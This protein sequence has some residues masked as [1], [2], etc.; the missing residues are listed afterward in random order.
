[1]Q[2]LTALLLAALLVPEPVPT[3]GPLELGEKLLSQKQYARAEAELQRAVAADPTSARAHGNLALAFLP[4]RKVR[5]ALAEARLAAAFGPASPEAHYIY[6][7]ALS[8]DGKPVEAAR[9]YEKADALKPGQAGVLASLAAAYAAAEDPRTVGAYERL[10]L[11]RPAEPR[12]RGDLAEYLWRTEKAEDGDKVMEEALR[13]FPTDA[14]LPLRY[15]RFLAQQERFVDAAAQLE[16]AR[17]LGAKD[18][19]TYALLARVYEQAGRGDAARSTLVLAV[20]AHPREASLQHDLGRL[21]LAEGK[22]DDAFPHL[23][24]AV[25]AQPNTADYQ[26]DFGR[27]L[28]AA[29]QLEAAESAYRRAVSLAPASPRAHYSLGRLLQR[30][31][32]KEEAERELAT[33][34]ALYERGRQ[35]VSAADATDAAASFAWAE[36]NAGRAAEALRR[37]QALP[38]GPE[39]LRGQ[40]LALQRLQRHEEAVRALERAL[41]LAPDDARV[42]LLLAAERS[43]TEGPK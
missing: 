31:G 3:P 40:A 20:A 7:L 12:Y 36:L 33:H 38:E 22:T 2:A 15:G 10:F 16:T 28:E 32:K 11:A 21:W 39:A 17:R 25:Q 14:G 9:E 37:F 42:E 19:S 6:G 26:L 41:Q 18:A 5:E 1:M 24:A 23:Q 4:Q 8:A 35:L 13:L 30:Q 34:H 27:A 29:G 43:R